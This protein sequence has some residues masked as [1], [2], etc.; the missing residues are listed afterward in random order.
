MLATQMGNRASTLV[1]EMAHKTIYTPPPVNYTRR[2]CSFATTKDGDSIAMRLYSDTA[3]AEARFCA[4]ENTVST[5]DLLIFSHGNGSDIGAMH[6]FCEHLCSALEMDVL[7]Y[8]YPGYGHSSAT[9][10]CEK[11]ICA[12]LDAVFEACLQLGWTQTRIFL[13]G[14]SLG[15]VPTLHLA[16]QPECHVSGVVLLAPL[17]SGSR[18]LLQDSKYVP[19]WI[20]GSMDF[21]LFNNMRMI[22]DVSC[23]IAIVHGTGDHI[24]SVAHTEALKQKIREASAYPSL[25]VV[26]GHNDVVDV[27]SRDLMRITEYIKRFRQKCLLS[28]TQWI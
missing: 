17:A 27:H 11:K 6:R 22:S 24:V 16:S 26:G 8:D 23:P 12:S 20:A 1:E 21:V 3:D 18:V 2:S 14:H 7:V 5:R 15:S 28:V 10:A 13:M 25:F 4:A 9:K 19:T